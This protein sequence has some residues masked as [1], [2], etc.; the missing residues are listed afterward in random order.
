MEE[1]MQA[2]KRAKPRS[3]RIRREIASISP[4]VDAI[5]RIPLHRARTPNIVMHSETPEA[6]PSSSASPVA[7][8]FPVSVPQPIPARSRTVHKVFSIKKPPAQIMNRYDYF[9]SMPEAF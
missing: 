7:R 9:R 8:A 6:A 4:E 2:D 1:P 3:G 5:S